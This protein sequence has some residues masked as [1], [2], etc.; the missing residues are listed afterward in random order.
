MARQLDFFRSS[1]KEERENVVLDEDPIHLLR[2]LVSVSRIDL[3]AC[4]GLIND[5]ISDDEFGRLL[6]AWFGNVARVLL[7]G[8]GFYVWGGCRQQRRLHTGASSRW[9]VLVVPRWQPPDPDLPPCPP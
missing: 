3:A 9:P 5:D 6:T 1:G 8:R 2:P 4:I 7:P